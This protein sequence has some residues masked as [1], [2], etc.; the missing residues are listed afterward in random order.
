APVAREVDDRPLVGSKRGPVVGAGLHGIDDFNRAP[1]EI[2]RR[3]QPWGLRRPASALLAR[4]SKPCTERS[5]RDGLAKGGRRPRGGP[6]E[7]AG[8]WGGW[9]GGGG[10]GLQAWR[11]ISSKGEESSL[12][13]VAAKRSTA[14]SK[15]ARR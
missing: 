14:R 7:G 12:G 15:A 4:W 13:T 8:G 2:F 6:A 10:S 5:R 11:T 9:G 1:R 3:D